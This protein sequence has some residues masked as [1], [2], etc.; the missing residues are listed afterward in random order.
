[1]FAAVVVLASV[2]VFARVEVQRSEG[3]QREGRPALS[4][5][6]HKAW[7]SS[8]AFSHDGKRLA[9]GGDDGMVKVWDAMSGKEVLTIRAD[10]AV[11]CVAYSREG[12]R[13]ASGGWDRVVRVWDAESGKEVLVLKGH[14]ESIT[15]VAFSPDGKRIASGSGDDT[16]KVWDAASGNA[17]FT[18]ELDDDYDITCLAF[19][20]DG[21]YIATG[22][23]EK[24]L[25]VWDASNG[26]EVLTADGHD[27]AISCVA[28]SPDGKRIASGSEDGSV[29]VWDAQSG[30]ELL[31]LEGHK[32]S[33]AS[34]AFSPDGKRIASGSEDGSV[35]VWD[36]Q[37]CKESF[38]LRD[39]PDKVTSVAFSPDGK[40]IASASKGVLK[41]WA[42][43]MD[44]PASFA[45]DI[46]PFLKKH[47]LGCHGAKKQTFG[48]RFDHVEKYRSED[49]PLWTKVHE[50]LASKS[51]PPDGREQ[52]GDSE[53]KRIL[54]WI[55]E[56]QRTAPAANLRRLN[57]RE[58]SAAL[59]DL[60]GLS[61]D[62]ADALPADAKLGGFDT[63]TDAL[64]DAA[65]SV[66]QAM[67]VTRRAVDAIRF[68]GPATGT[69]FAADLPDV[70]DPRKAFDAWKDKGAIAKTRGFALPGK[71][72]LLEPRWV[73]ERDDHSFTLPTPKDNRGVLR[74]KLS[75]S[76]LKPVEG[77]PNPRLWVRIGG[78]YIT[79]AEVTS[80]PEK[81][82]ELVYL[83]QFDDLAIDSKGVKVSLSNKVE[84]PYSVKG[85]ENEE[86]VR[87]GEVVPG[88]TGWFRPAFD[89]KLPPQKQPAPSIVLRSIEIETGHV[90]QWPPAS[91][92]L[93][94]GPT[95]DD[96]TS[97]KR[98]L[99]VWIERAWRR[100]A[101]EK[102]QDKYI[103]LYRK[104]RTE[105]LSFDEALRATFQSV[106]LGGFRYL[107]P[108]KESQQAL[109]SRI[110]FMLWGAPPD[111]EIRKL[112]AEGKL[113]D[114]ATLNAQVD[115]L[116]ADPRSDGFIR[117]FVLQWLE[118]EQPITVASSSLKKQDF[119]F[120]RYLKASMKEETVDYIARLFID[121]RPAKELVASDWTMM[122][123]SLAIHYGY[124]DV[125]GGHLRKVTLGKDDPRGGG[126]LGHAGIQSM[127]TWMGGNWV[128]YRGAWVMRHVL[129]EPP[130]PPPLEVPE[131]NPSEG[132]NRGKSFK[133]L[134][135]QHQ[136][137]ANCAVC[138]KK[139]D[140]VGF[141]F[142]NF[143]ISGRW[144]DREYDGYHMADLDGRIE[145]RGV[146]KERAVDTA[147]KLPRGEKFTTFAEFKQTLVKNYQADMVRGVL[148]N[149]VIYATGRLPDVHDM[150]EIRRIMKEHEAKGY[151]MRD[152][153]KSL[154][155]SKA[156]LER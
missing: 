102:E 16:L 108:A 91:W 72:L 29:K 10:S 147:G 28:Y 30:K 146:G 140:P 41:V 17:L 73:G 145:W 127:L 13:L 22:D 156:F 137:N 7:V 151:P 75:V 106:L 45:K 76:A 87:K 35:K 74:L 139:M 65:D 4:L 152:V 153:L 104:L 2:Q 8:V 121:N 19:S 103:A 150:A 53:R 142:Q 32:E 112:A 44:E 123:D 95:R 54:A 40:R 134:L 115:R 118:M 56:A 100:P 12:K 120:A 20:P 5:N 107:P 93:G 144:R 131:L 60:T 55:E 66:E 39:H 109:A 98:L 26:K 31:S 9:S 52:P 34:V 110:S 67:K 101:S 71:G 36:A 111:A 114:P 117:P 143:D 129:D 113:R 15:F 128:I 11:S 86:V 84:I 25:T 80:S 62:H 97:A 155:R 48:I 49:N 59:Q 21:K 57:R 94:L 3:E 154:L 78:K 92:K 125:E 70:K 141:A 133:E 99:S 119:R 1:M 85:Y 37:S 18:V 27:A 135:K 132:K 126:V 24:R 51:M 23:G 122:N 88:G 63:G 138:H 46:Q 149:L 90:A 136:E 64:Q 82:Q 81:P 68:L 33:V 83:V 6:A 105:K 77:L 43:H 116:L 130:P 79:F 89:R 69:V 42:N 148:K 124:K 61:V 38:S 50:A 47:C 58:L 14:K 96:E